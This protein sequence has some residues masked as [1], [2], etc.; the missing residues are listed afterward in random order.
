MKL[1]WLKINSAWQPLTFKGVAAFS[2][3]SLKR[4][5]LVQF[6]FA[7]FVA[8][9]VAWLLSHAW[10][11]TVRQAILAL[12][13]TGRLVA[14]KLD[15]TNEPPRLLAESSF[16][17]V[18]TDLEHTG[19]IRVPADIQIELGR[20]DV[21]FVSLLGYRDEPYP[22]RR[23][24]EFNRLT[25]EPRWGA[26]RPPILWIVFGIVFA[27]LMLIWWTLASFYFLPL[28]LIGYL[29]NRRLSVLGSWKLV[30]A[31]LMSGAVLM[32][33]GLL[34]YGSGLVDPVGLMAVQ[35]AHL[36]AGIVYC[37]ASVFFLPKLS[38]DIIPKP[39][40]FQP[41]EGTGSKETPAKPENPFKTPGG[42]A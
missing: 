22:S 1:D 11:P 5:L 6:L 15:W 36:V 14:G 13:E 20:S 7:L 8:A 27:S 38:E 30:G 18:I 33:L 26:W 29:A 31:A 2:T 35:V 23:A 19:E 3:A 41:A 4:L 34:A 16:L 39:N 37:S 9:T 42:T 12:P 21:R 10:F 17:A 32:A 40:P 25:L 28:W 24:I